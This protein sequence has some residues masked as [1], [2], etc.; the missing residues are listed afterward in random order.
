MESNSSYNDFSAEDFVLDGSFQRYCSGTDEEARKFWSHWLSLHPHKQAE[1]HRAKEMYYI[2]NGGNSGEQFD[3]HKAAFGERLEKAG[4]KTIAASE[5]KVVELPLPHTS[6]KRIPVYRWVA[7]AVLLLAISLSIGYLAGEK[8]PAEHITRTPTK[9]TDIEPGGDKAVLTLANGQKIVLDT[10]ANGA[11]TD[12]GGIT[13]IKLGGQLSY[14]DGDEEG[15]E[16]LYNTIST[17]KGGQYQLELADG[18]KVWLNAASSL[19]FPNKFTGKDRTVELTGEGY[20]EI[21]H[22]PQAPFHVKVNDMDVQVLGTQFNVNSYTDEPAVATTLLEGKVRVSKGARYLNLNPGQRAVVPQGE[23]HI[24]V[25]FKADVEEAIAWKNGLI[26]FDGSDVGAVMR[27]IARWYNVDVEYSGNL[28]GAHLSGKVSRS[29]Q[30]SQVVKILE[31][32]G[33]NVRMEGRKLI[34]APKL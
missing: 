30:L 3:A 29:L 24:R 12:Q 8:K 25:E 13:I 22:N 20:F 15:E 31:E 21:A 32:L 23:D 18:S 6:G 7:A 34:A 10:A 16:V 14:A 5:A 9:A 17:P 1:V 11:L 26:Y 28:K 27:Q 2:I 19:R 33:I 4:I